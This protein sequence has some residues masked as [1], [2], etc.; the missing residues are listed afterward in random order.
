MT[1]RT[2]FLD[3]LIL[4][5]ASF[6]S[7][8]AAAVSSALRVSA[9][10]VTTAFLGI[11]L[12]PL[13]IVFSGS[14]SLRPE[15]FFYRPPHMRVLLLAV[16][17]APATLLLEWG[18]HITVGFARSGVV[19]RRLEL[20]RFWGG[21]WSAGQFLLLASIALG[22]EVVFRQIWISI[23]GQSLGFTPLSALTG[24]AAIYGINHLYFGW[25]SVLAKTLAG[26]VYGG[27]F[28]LDDRS[29]F[30]PFLAH[31]LQNGILLSIAAKPD[32]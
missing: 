31:A 30:A 8:F 15:L 16:V 2:L 12:T 9:R 18:F 28:L 1:I 22:E 27:L 26:I 3:S 4:T 6:P 20:H 19:Q 13:V 23:L 21:R 17:A 14:L 10:Q 11:V 32:V 24:S 5:S 7:G 25:S 29:L